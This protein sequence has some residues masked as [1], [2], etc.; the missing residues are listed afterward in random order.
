MLSLARASIIISSACCFSLSLSTP[1]IY[2]IEFA[3]ALVQS[4]RESLLAMGYMGI[5]RP[6]WRRALPGERLSA[7]REIVQTV[8]D[9]LSSARVKK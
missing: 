9:A 5:E 6:L 1:A 3:F 4:E 7:G 2:N 8:C